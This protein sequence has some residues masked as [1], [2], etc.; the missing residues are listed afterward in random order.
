LTQRAVIGL[1]G[2][3]SKTTPPKPTPMAAWMNAH[4][5][6]I[7]A[8]LSAA[9][10]VAD[11]AK[12]GHDVTVEEDCAAVMHDSAT[13]ATWAPPPLDASQ[14][15][16]YVGETRTWSNDC[17]GSGL[18]DQDASGPGLV[19]ALDAATTAWNGFYKHGILAD[20]A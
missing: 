1:V 14:W 17:G 13:E 11:Q 6:T 2:D 5:P 4:R 10:A 19:K 15:T 12:A 9:S 20:G 3:L 16:T 8:T 7:E 18:L